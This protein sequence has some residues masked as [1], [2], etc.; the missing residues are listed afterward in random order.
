MAMNWY[1]TSRNSRQTGAGNRAS[2]SDAMCGNAVMFD[3]V[4]GMILSVGRSPDYQGTDATSNAHV[5]TI[6]APNTNPTVNMINNIANKRIFANT[7]VLPNKEV[8]VT[9]RQTYGNPF[10]DANAVFTP[11]MWNPSTN[12]FTSIQPNSIPRT[13]HLMALL[14]IDRTIL[15]GGR[16]LCG[17]CSSNHFDAQIYTPPYLLNT[18]GSPATRPNILTLSTT[19]V[20]VS[21]QVTVTTDSG[22]LQISLIRFGSTTHTVDT[23][24]RRI[25]LT[26]TTTGTN[27]YAFTVPNDPGIALP[28]Y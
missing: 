13:Y 28:G 26:F 1:N 9:S 24:Q 25:A 12:A 27:K 5:I 4:K 14:L 22:I 21:G 18:D 20:A 17:T 6:R 15:S 2:D 16:G 19:T 11:E 23:D 8:F 7:V 3:A 10:S